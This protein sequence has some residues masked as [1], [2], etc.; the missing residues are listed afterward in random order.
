MKLKKIFLNKKIFFLWIKKL[1][2]LK[3]DKIYKIVE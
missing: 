3:E 1:K 2:I